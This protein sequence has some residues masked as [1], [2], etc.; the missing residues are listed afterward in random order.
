LCGE[1]FFACVILIA[2]L[3]MREWFKYE[4]G[5][6]NVD[7]ENLY[8]TNTGNWVETESLEEKTAKANQKNG[9]RKYWMIGFVALVFCLFA[10]LL[11]KNI[12]SGKVSIG[13]ILL[14]AIGG[15]QLYNYLRTE[16]GAKFKIPL[17]KITD[18]KEIEKT[19]EIS[20]TNGEGNSD[21]YTLSGI[22]EK[23]ILIMNK[24]KQGQ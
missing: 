18:I 9:S 7:A 19:I 4:Y 5:Y 21:N 10:F 23:G 14:I 24:L 17:K 3:F 8:L 11:F 13:L 15:Y 22:E 2:A 20:F 12:E 6:V 16:I 1:L